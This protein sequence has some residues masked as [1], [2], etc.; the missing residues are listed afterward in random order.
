[1]SSPIDVKPASFTMATTETFPLV[2][3][4][5]PNLLS[6]ETLSS[7][8]SVM[9]DITNG[10]SVPVSLPDMPSVV[11]VIDGFG[12]SNGIQQE[13]RGTSL[14]GGHQYRLLVTGTVTSSKVWTASLTINVPF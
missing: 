1:M 11:N 14:L 8:V 3:D 5:S 9:N 13:I 2:F 4:F 12:T 7:P 6:G 10:L